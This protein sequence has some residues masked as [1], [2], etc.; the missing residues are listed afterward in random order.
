MVGVL[1]ALAPRRRS[2]PATTGVAPVAW[3]C[4]LLRPDRFRAVIGLSVPYRGRG[5][6]RPTTVMPQTDTALFYQLYFQTPGIAE[7]ELER[8]AKSTI[9][10]ML[11]A[12]SGDASQGSGGAGQA[13]STVAWWIERAAFSQP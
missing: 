6:V 10:R 9:R 2:S 5:P 12:A 8:D 4:A 7:A 1:D 3:H 13:G 11:Y